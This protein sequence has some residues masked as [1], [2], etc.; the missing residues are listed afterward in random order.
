[1]DATKLAPE[2]IVAEAKVSFGHLKLRQW[3]EEKEN[4]KELL[5]EPW[6]APLATVFRKKRGKSGWAVQHLHAARCAALGGYVEQV[7]LF[8]QGKVAIPMCPHC[9]QAEGTNQHAYYVC[10]A[11]PFRTVA[12]RATLL[13]WCSWGQRL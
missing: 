3:A 5:P 10:S 1:M 2:N 8:N 13:M 6:M 11:E 12:S 7:Q 4:R 9:K